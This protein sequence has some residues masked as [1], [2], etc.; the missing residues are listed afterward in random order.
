MSAT[1][2]IQKFVK[3]FDNKA[4][5]LSIKGRMYPVEIFY[6]PQAEPDYVEA[7]IRTAVQI[8][9]FEEEGDILIFLTGEEEIEYVVS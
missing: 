4:P 2:E 7:C 8:H 9:L 3:Y 5:V 1:I 6:L